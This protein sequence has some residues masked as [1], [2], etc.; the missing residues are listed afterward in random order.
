MFPVEFIFLGGRRENEI[1]DEPENAGGEHLRRTL[2]KSENT[3][4]KLL[5]RSIF[6]P[7]SHQATVFV[8]IK[9]RK[10]IIC[11]IDFVV[12]EIN[13]LKKCYCNANSIFY[14]T[15]V[16]EGEEGSVCTRCFLKNVNELQCRIS[17]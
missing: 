12:K 7:T 13:L 4:Y 6:K 15:R 9:Y 8:H 5:V 14:R 3:G 16:A 11:V 2:L 17:L 10:I 1:T